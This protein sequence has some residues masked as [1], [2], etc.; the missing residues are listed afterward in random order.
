MPINTKTAYV[1][2]IAKKYWNCRCQCGIALIGV[3]FASRKEKFQTGDSSPRFSS[4]RF[5]LQSIFQTKKCDTGVNPK[6]RIMSNSFSRP[7]HGVTY[8]PTDLFV[9]PL[10]VDRRNGIWRMNILHFV[11]Y[12]SKYWFF[13][14]ANPQILEVSWWTKWDMKF[15]LGPKCPRGKCYHSCRLD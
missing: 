3:G 4:A 15:T 5:F 10:R 9:G 11:K 8:N 1:N 2:K 13:L 6:R 7:L 12:Y 14:K